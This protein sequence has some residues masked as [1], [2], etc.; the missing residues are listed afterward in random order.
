MLVD[1]IYDL[2]YDRFVSPEF[3]LVSRCVNAAHELASL[4]LCWD[5]G[6]SQVWDGPLPEIVNVQVTRDLAESG[7]GN[8]RP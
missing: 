2:L 5:P 6:Q 8:D 1:D 4:S 3:S 7:D